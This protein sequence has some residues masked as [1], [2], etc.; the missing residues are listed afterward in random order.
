MPSAVERTR[1]MQFWPD[2]RWGKEPH[3]HLWF[4]LARTR[5]AVYRARQKDLSESGLTAEQSFVLSIVQSLVNQG[6]ADKVTPAEISR[7]MFRESQSV[8]ELLQ[9]MEREGLV[10]KVKDLERKN[11]VRVE[12]AKK[13]RD[14]FE[15]SISSASM[16]R[17]MSH[18]SSEQRE[19]LTTCL[20]IIREAA[21][22]ELGVDD[23]PILISYD[24]Q[25]KKRS[26]ANESGARN[27]NGR[28]SRTV[29][30]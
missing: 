16:A 1:A 10:A 20:T 4:L 25:P 6:M 28:A 17:I 5:D 9:R 19:Q 18:L 8:S 26:S 21:L 22:D 23:V 11:M 3:L 29:V 2:P 15:A 7:Q 27:S 14:Q 30:D 13:G 12:L 24:T